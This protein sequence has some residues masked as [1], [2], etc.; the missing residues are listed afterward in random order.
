MGVLK[1]DVGRP[2]NNTKKI[3][4]I[5]KGILIF[6]VFFCIGYTVSS[7]FLHSDEKK[8]DAKKEEEIKE[9]A[10]NAQE[11]LNEN[12]GN[13]YLSLGLTMI[14]GGIYEIGSEH[15][16]I[17]Y[18]DNKIKTLVSLNLT[19]ASKENDDLCNYF[20][21]NESED[22]EGYYTIDNSGCL[23]EKNINVYDIKEV[24]KTFEAKFKNGKV[25][26][27]NLGQEG[28]EYFY[29][30]KKYLKLNYIY[31][32]GDIVGHPF[33]EVYRNYKK[34]N[35]LFIEMVTSPIK[36]DSEG[37]Y[38]YLLAKD[39]LKIKLDFKD[40][41]DFDNIVKEYGS[42]LRSYTLKFELINGKYVFVEQDKVI[43][44]K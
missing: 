27:E 16:K 24:E 31:E 37:E 15:Y 35:Q 41:E 23:Y 43:E 17:D 9:N 34:G 5:L 39:D 19:K 18:N 28:S 36:Y 26:K 2:S 1:N 20:D 4:L 13:N 8:T 40:A 38:T 11:F 33:N 12:F 10:I 7:I 30:D 22:L 44:V 14:D 6:I 3:R 32:G 25:I 21:C 42:K 29:K